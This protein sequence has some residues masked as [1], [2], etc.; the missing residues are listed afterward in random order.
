MA[1]ISFF[2]PDSRAGSA[3]GLNAAGGNIGVSSVKC[4][5]RLHSCWYRTSS[6]AARP[7][8]A[9]QPVEHVTSELV[10]EGVDGR[11]SSGSIQARAVELCGPDVGDAQADCSAI[12]N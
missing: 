9:R 12:A 7:R 4:S 2:H 3:L 1:H 11:V 6:C 5:C 10:Q 8:Q